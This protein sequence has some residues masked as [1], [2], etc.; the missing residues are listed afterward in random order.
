MNLI[1]LI[2]RDVEIMEVINELLGYPYLKIYQDPERFNFSVDS[3]IVA[4][5]ATIKYTT[6]NIIDL[7]TGNAPIPLFLTLRTKAHIDAVEIQE[8]SYNLARKSISINKLED[9]ISLYLDDVRGISKK[10]GFQKYDLVISNP[11][12]FKYQES[13]N[14]NKNDFKTIARHEVMLDLDSLCKEVV[15]L[16]NNGGTFTMVHRPDRLTDIISTLR[17]HGLEPKRIRFVYPKPGCEAN[18]VLIESKRSTSEGGL[19]VLPPLVVHNEDG[20]YSS[21]ILEIY[22]QRDEVNEKNL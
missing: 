3:M 21:E 13:S 11:P 15:Q 12:F 1:L 10:L 9:R 14:I 6:K 16:L 4:A 19:K 20:S 7:G 2:E 5:F 8:G 22:N 17:S 18:H